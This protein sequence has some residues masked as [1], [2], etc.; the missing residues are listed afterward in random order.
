MTTIALKRGD[1][2][3]VAA[4]L[5]QDSGAPVD[6]TGYVVRS[7]VRTPQGALVAELSVVVTDAPLGAYTL[8][9]TAPETQLWPVGRHACDVQYTSAGGVVSSTATF[10]VVV[11]E[12]VTR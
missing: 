8:A 11:S 5:A 2:L 4:A 10:P 6:L 1:T 12:D 7:Q 9:A 3:S